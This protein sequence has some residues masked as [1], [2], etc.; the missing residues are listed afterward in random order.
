MLVVAGSMEY[1]GAALL[2]GRGAAR[3]GAGVVCLATPESVGARLLGAAPELTAMLLDEEAPGLIGPA[4]WRRVATE[5]RSFEALVVGPGLGRHPSM[6][7]RVRGFLHEL[8]QPLV[9]DADGL[10]ALATEKQWWRP[11]TAPAV[12]T[13]HPGEFARLLGRTL[14]PALSDDDDARVA[15]ASAAASQWGQV[16]VLKGA[17]TVVAGPD[18]TLLRSEV[19]TASLATAG[20]G[21]V[22]AGAIGALFGSRLLSVVRGRLRRGGAQHGGPAGPGAHRAIGRHCRGHRQPSARGSR[23]PAAERPGVMER[24]APSSHR[25]WVEVDHAAL[26]HNLGALRRLAGP[27]KRVIAVVKANAYGHG[28]IE[29]SRTLLAEGAELLAVATIDEGIT[30]RR[31]GVSAPIVVLWALGRPEAALAVAHDLQPIVHDAAGIAMLEEAA[32]AG[33]RLAVHLKVDTGLGRQGADPA[34]AVELAT[35]LGRS[36]RLQLAG[37]FS[38][39]AVPG[40]DDAYTDVQLVRLAQTLDAMRSAG[41]DP[42]LVHVSATGGILAGAGA[43]ADAVRPGLGLYGMLPAW[44]SDRDPGL[45]PVLSLKALPIRIFDLPAGQ[46]I[47][48]GL[49]YRPARATRIATL[50]IGYGDGWPRLHANNG[51]VL[52]RGRPAPIVG[53]ISMDGLTVDLGQIDEV[54][55]DD[56]FVLIGEQSGA[57]VSAD[58][59]AAERRTINYEVTTAL[60]GRLPRL[61]LGV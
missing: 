24:P 19:A 14:D 43:F 8:R 57:R 25:A 27:E 16:V 54:T 58:E 29:V 40:E 49:R 45:R 12:L 30:L 18:G 17:H 9:I 51:Q 2:A 7:R 5:A 44:A 59:V 55:Y 13:P 32:D 48:Y 33:R 11:L 26:R 42:G 37:T 35:R 23:A 6:Q 3:A 50:G 20:S 22:L 39:L 47:G 53:A 4:G 41:V 38:H 28:A 60:R 15:A 46:P 1:A 34:T 10:N 36:R 21:D 61:H 52:V 31:A 56:E